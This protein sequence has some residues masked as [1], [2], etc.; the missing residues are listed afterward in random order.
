MES[1][2]GARQAVAYDEALAQ[3]FRDTLHGVRGVSEKRMMGGL[4]LFVDGNMIGGV[5][6]TKDAADRF[7]FRVGKENDA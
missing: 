7:M 1:M 6:R 4:C 3:R 2:H 5:D